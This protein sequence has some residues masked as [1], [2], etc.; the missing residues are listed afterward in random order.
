[1]PPL[2]DPW[3]VSSEPQAIRVAES[4]GLL[5]Q[6]TGE[7]L[8][9]IPTGRHK[10]HSGFRMKISL[11]DMVQGFVQISNPQGKVDAWEIGSTRAFVIEAKHGNA[12]EL[13]SRQLFYPFHDLKMKLQ[14]EGHQ[15]QSP[16]A[17]RSSFS[18]G[19]QSS[20]RSF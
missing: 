15:H 10:L 11:N 9:S 19:K 18:G 1:M 17:L 8:M 2:V 5:E 16:L 4:T 13:H 12:K 7:K 20:F 3:M 14:D 6:F